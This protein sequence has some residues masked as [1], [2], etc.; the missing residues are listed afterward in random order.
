MPGATDKLCDTEASMN[1]GVIAAINAVAL[2]ILFL[3]IILALFAR[4]RQ[5]KEALWVQSVQYRI[6]MCH[7]SLWENKLK[8]NYKSLW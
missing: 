8:D 4:R 6:L 5:T 3:I 1:L 7:N 2:I